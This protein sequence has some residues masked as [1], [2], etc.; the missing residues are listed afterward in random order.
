[1][2]D[3]LLRFLRG[4]PEPRALDTGVR[5]LCFLPEEN[6]M[7]KPGMDELRCEAALS[8]MDDDTYSFM[9]LR[10]QQAGATIGE[11][12][13]LGFVHPETWPAVRLTL[14]RCAEVGAE[15]G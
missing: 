3:K 13:V 5:Y 1:M 8:L 11:V 15:R 14:E 2:I 6:P 10:V 9:L 7:E 4:T 12:K